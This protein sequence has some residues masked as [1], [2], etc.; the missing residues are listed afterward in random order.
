MNLNCDTVLHAESFSCFIFQFLTP[1]T[2][3]Y[4]LATPSVIYDRWHTFV[5]GRHLL[6]SDEKTLLRQ[7]YVYYHCI[8][9]GHSYALLLI[10]HILI[11]TL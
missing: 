5:S 10:F 3:V 1:Y 6:Y 9:I 11:P 8:F 7:M 4:Q 2:S